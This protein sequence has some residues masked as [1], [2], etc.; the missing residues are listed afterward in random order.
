[1]DAK[2]IADLFDVNLGDDPAED[3]RVEVTTAA[4]SFGSKCD[5]LKSIMQSDDTAVIKD[6]I[7]SSKKNTR[8][9]KAYDQEVDDDIKQFALEAASSAPVLQVQPAE[10]LDLD[11]DTNKCETSSA[12]PLALP[13]SEIPTF[14]KFCSEFP[15]FS[16]NNN[17]LAFRDFYQSKYE[18]LKNLVMRFPIL[19]CKSMAKEMST[20]RTD[21]YIGDDYISPDL[22]QKKLDD[23][24]RWRTRVSSLLI[25]AL[26][27]FYAWERFRDLLS[28]KLWK[29]HWVKGADRRDGLVLEH[30]SDVERYVEDMRGFIEGAKAVDGMLKAASESLSRQL[31]CLQ[32]REYVGGKRLEELDKVEV[33]AVI[34]APK[35]TGGA[36]TLEYGRE[37]EISSLGG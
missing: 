3:G 16:V 36:T 31:T 4:V 12:N 19:D 8:I 14:Q 5:D 37:D 21:H 35:K 23:S 7:L 29:D 11:D 10:V 28:A 22:V 20:V 1:M 32:L 33:G 17:A 27:Q 15:Q 26:E 9:S 18:A 2:S 25:S 6:A 30:L 34:S 24:Y 13:T